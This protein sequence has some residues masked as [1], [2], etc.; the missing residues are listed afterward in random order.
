MKPWSTIAAYIAQ[1]TGKP[2]EPRPPS[3]VGGGCINTAV[4]LSD[5]RRSFFVKLNSAERL[6][7]FAAEAEGLG[8]MAQS[9]CIRVPEPVCHGTVDGQ[10]YLVMEHIAMGRPGGDGPEQAGRQLAAMHRNGRERFGWHRDNT[11]G[12]THQPNT[13]SADWIEFWREQRLGFQLRLA[14]RN[15]H[16][17]RLQSQGEKLLER[18]P[19][20]IDHNPQ[21]AL[22]HG[23][24]WGGNLAYDNRGN[25]VIYDPAVYYAD[26]EA[27]LA[28]TELFGRQSAGFYAAYNEAWPL[29]SGY[30]TRRDLYNLYHILN[31]LNLFGGGY[32]GQALG[33]IDRLLAEVGH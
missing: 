2:F 31:H 25:P 19:A 16:G 17:G 13:S 32:G 6:E 33:M 12:S 10:A 24:L 9:H 1:A 8:E 23:D 22:L 29:D 5:H 18:F 3:S 4:K 20:L 21:P 30:A 27:E 15:G 26:R 11:I 7:M 28:M 14:A